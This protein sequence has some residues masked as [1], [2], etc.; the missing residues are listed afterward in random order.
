MGVLIRIVNE[1]QLVY[2]YSSLMLF[3]ETINV[4]WAVEWEH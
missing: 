4:E 2:R 3:T 1:W